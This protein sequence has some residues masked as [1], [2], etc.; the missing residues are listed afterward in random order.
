MRAT[1]HFKGG[2]L[3]RLDDHL[4]DPW[5]GN[6]ISS[7]EDDVSGMAAGSYPQAAV[8]AGDF[9]FWR[10]GDLEKRTRRQFFVQ[11]QGT[12]L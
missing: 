3:Q 5:H 9:S 7:A 10:K 1:F 12:R 8:S 11:G 2:W 4:A 6:G